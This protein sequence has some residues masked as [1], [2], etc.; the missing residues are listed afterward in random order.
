MENIFGDC[1]LRPCIGTRISP[2][3]SNRRDTLSLR[4][5]KILAIIVFAYD[6]GDNRV[7]RIVSLDSF[8]ENWKIRASSFKG[9]GNCADN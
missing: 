8:H 1:K 7:L 3:Q 6:R 2:K 5:M 9:E 4:T